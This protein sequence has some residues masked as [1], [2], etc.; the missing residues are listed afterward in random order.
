MA[1]MRAALDV[2]RSSYDDTLRR[3]DFVDGV[4]TVV[5]HE[6]AS[7]PYPGVDA[8]MAV[9]LALFVAYPRRSTVL[10][11]NIGAAVYVAVSAATAALL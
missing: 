11:V 4:R 5:L 8:F 2:M 6:D 3:S 7:V 1:A 10:A 9:A